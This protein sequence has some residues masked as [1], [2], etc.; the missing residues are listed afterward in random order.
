MNYRLNKGDVYETPEYLTENILKKEDL[1]GSILEPCCASG[2]MSRAIEGAGYKVRSFDIREDDIYGEGGVDFLG[3]TEK[4]DT[5]ITNPPYSIAQ[6]IV[7]HAIE[8]SNYKVIMLLKLDWLAGKNRREFYENNKPK[9]IYVVSNR[10]TLYPANTPEPENR[11]RI[12]Y[13]WF[14]WEKGYKGE[15]I[16][17][18]V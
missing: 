11:G 6:K 7:E 14:V 12:E 5:I 8:Y 9:K 4:Y 13:A 16:V 10:P 18:W 15:F 2:K 1:I 17:D 3:F